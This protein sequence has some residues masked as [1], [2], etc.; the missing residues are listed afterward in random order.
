MKIVGCGLIVITVLCVQ[1]TVK[2]YMQCM[3]VN[4]SHGVLAIG[5][6]KR[7]LMIDNEAQ[8]NVKGINRLQEERD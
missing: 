2:G 1:C 6:Y 4:S 7:L 5:C 3:N 8:R